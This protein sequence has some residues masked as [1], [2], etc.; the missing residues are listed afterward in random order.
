MTTPIFSA[1][2]FGDTRTFTFAVAVTDKKP[3]LCEKAFMANAAQTAEIFK[4]AEAEGVLIT[5]AMCKA[6]PSRRFYSAA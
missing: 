5:E 1:V 6:P 2:S 3:V 4:L